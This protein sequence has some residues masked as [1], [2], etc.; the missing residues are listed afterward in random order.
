MS[1]MVHFIGCN[2]LDE[3]AGFSNRFSPEGIEETIGI[4]NRDYDQEDTDN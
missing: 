4:A 1:W 3:L 2:Q